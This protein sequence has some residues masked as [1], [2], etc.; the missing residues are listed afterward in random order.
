[1]SLLNKYLP[2][3]R[4]IIFLLS[5]TDLR[6]KER[7]EER[8]TLIWLIYDLFIDSYMCPDQL[9]NPQ[10]C[11]TRDNTLTNWVTWLGPIGLYSK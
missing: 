7:N 10:P 6:E 4:D 5:I 3:Y 1:M 8:E 2:C 9:S 11:L